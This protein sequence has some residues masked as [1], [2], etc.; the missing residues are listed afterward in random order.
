MKLVR[1]SRGRRTLRAT[2]WCS[3]TSVVLWIGCSAKEPSPREPTRPE[4]AASLSQE[5]GRWLEGAITE[6][7]DV[8]D[9]RY[10]CVNADNRSLWLASTITEVRVGDILQYREGLW[11]QDLESPALDRR[12]PEILFVDQILVKSR[13]PVPVQRVAGLPS[14]HPVIPQSSRRSRNSLSPPAKGT[15]PEL[16]AAVPIHEVESNGKEL[17]GKTVSV[18][19]LVSKINRNIMGKNWI[20]L[21]DD[22]GGELIVTTDSMPG[23][24]SIV[25]ARGVL[26][27][28]K[29]FKS[30]YYIPLFLEDAD[31]RSIESESRAGSP[32][33]RRASA[34][35]SGP[36]ATA[37][38]ARLPSDH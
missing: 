24:G 9:Y 22:R 36:A 14:G 16:D 26:T 29:T 7:I 33:L 32:S 28:D 15:L 4:S 21:L 23:L 20:H 6:V 27:S 37:R 31:V 18:V 12:F 35:E 17:G 11:M 34:G 30:G 5:S 19:G 13:A 3:L 38:P 1:N 2:L 8:G 10:L 25:S